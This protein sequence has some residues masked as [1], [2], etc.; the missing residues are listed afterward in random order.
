MLAGS[1]P[2]MKVPFLRRVLAQAGLSVL[3]ALFTIPSWGAGIA[4]SLGDSVTLSVKV[5]G[6][7]PFTYQWRH[8]GVTIGG[9]TEAI[10]RIASLGTA[11]AGNY[12]V[13]VSNAAGSS[14]SEAFVLTIN[15][16][17][18]VES[19]FVEGILCLSLSGVADGATP[20]TFQWYHNGTAVR[21][22]TGPDLLFP[23]TAPADAGFYDALVS[24][25]GD[26]LT[27]PTLVGYSLPNGSRSA[28][29]VTTQESW[30]NVVAPG[31]ARYDQF[32]L[33]G[34][35]GAIAAVPGRIARVSFLDRNGMIVQVG[36]SGAGTVSVGLAGASGP[37]QPLLYNQPGVQYVQGE[38]TIIVAGADETTH[39]SIYSVGTANNP[40]VTRSG[41]SYNGW[42]TIGAVGII[43]EGGKLGGLHMGNVAFAASRGYTGVFA[44]SVTQLVQSPAVLHNVSASADAIPLLCFG[45]AGQVAIR[46]AGGD[47]AQESGGAISVAGLMQVLM[48]TG[49]D[50]CARISSQKSI[51]T[52][53]LRD[54][55]D[56]TATLVAYR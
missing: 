30:Q 54:D 55:F 28:G 47:L 53:L 42:A 16:P 17:P 1:I 29:N 35:T 31:G 46:V 22:A 11:N 48:A 21:N 5:A 4:A 19:Q 2:A 10:L 25:G 13:S 9:A 14:V 41:V 49:G 50:S 40:G 45:P 37:Q 12:S 20:A 52:R 43:S 39:L 23:S 8:E 24:T 18:T 51:A 7:A 44:P 56:E 15:P 27:G 3:V 26:T 6:T 38:A 36:L 34:P 32:L 33:T